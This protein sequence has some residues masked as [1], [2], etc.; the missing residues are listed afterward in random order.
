MKEI[1]L[2]QG[3][4]ALVDDEAYEGLSKHK[5]CILRGKYT[6]YAARTVE[7]QGK[8]TMFLMHRDILHLIK[9]DKVLTHHKDGDGLNNQ[10][11]NLQCV[12]PSV[13]GYKKRM[14]RNNSS[15]F[16]GVSWDKY[17]KQWRANIAI[18]KQYIHL[19]RFSKAIEAAMV[20]DQA[21]KKYWKENAALNFP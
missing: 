15:Q 20:Y 17:R 16:R 9:G 7:R 11:N 2:T 8:V 6:F 12:T 18:N 13:N 4:I 19:G 5:W 3:K 1:N 14:Q 21:A 10:K